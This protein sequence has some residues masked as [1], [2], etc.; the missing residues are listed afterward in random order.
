MQEARRRV[1]WLVVAAAGVA[2]L[3]G[4]QG[5]L[6]GDARELRPLVDAEGEPRSLAFA[7]AQQRRA[8]AEADLPPG[9]PWY[10]GRADVR[11]SVEAGVQ[12]FT[13][14]RAATVTVDRQRSFR[15]RVFNSY[16]QTTY[17]ERVTE[18]WR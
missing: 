5:G 9:E 8:V 13:F 16:N 2:L 12:A 11:A 15:G 7:S 17:R 3:V 1:T 4:C 10:A 14:E 18:T 6:G